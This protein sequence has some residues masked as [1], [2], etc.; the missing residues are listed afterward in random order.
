MVLSPIGNWWQAKGRSAAHKMQNEKDKSKVAFQSG[1]NDPSRFEK[2]EDPAA[3]GGAYLTPNQQNIVKRLEEK[4]SRPG[5]RFALRVAGYSETKKKAEIL[6]GNFMP[7]LTVFDIEPFNG[8][9]K[10]R[11]FHKNGIKDLPIFKVTELV[12]EH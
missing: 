5:Y 3:Q 10:R 11:L 12:I 1:A 8:L 9:S 2:K 4:A 6:V 7:S